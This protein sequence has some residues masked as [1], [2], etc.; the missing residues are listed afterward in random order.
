MSK[1][2]GMAGWR[3]GAMVAPSELSTN[4]RKMQ[5]TNL[6]CAPVPSQRLATVLL[7]RGARWRAQ[8]IAELAARR[9][10]VLDELSVLE[11]VEIPETAGAFYFML[12]LPMC[13]PD[14]PIVERLIREF[15][16]A[17]IPG[18]AFGAGPRV[19]LRLAYASLTAKSLR[20]AATRLRDGLRAVCA[21]HRQ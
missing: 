10:E 5:D 20:T 6:I 8:R 3:I 2:F 13:A 11:G 12:R 4:L 16:V 14:M 7:T 21:E 18:S 15:G 9:L 19:H 17:L 1:S